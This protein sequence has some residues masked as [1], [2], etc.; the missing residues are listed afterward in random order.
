MCKILHQFLRVVACP[1]RGLTAEEPIS[2]FVW[3]RGTFSVALWFCCSPLFFTSVQ[4][5]LWFGIS[6]GS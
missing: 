4:R 1:G 5:S 2:A 6:V 3:S